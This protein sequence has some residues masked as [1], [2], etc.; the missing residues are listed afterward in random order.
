VSSRER[1][2]TVSD[3]TSLHVEVWRPDV[4]P[5]FVVVVA[6]GGAEHVHR[7][8]HLAQR[9]NARGGLVFG[10]DHRGQGL[11]DGPRGHVDEFATYARDLREVTRAVEAGLPAS[12][13][14]AACPWFLF[15]H[16]MGGLIA[17]TTLLDAPLEPAW[18]GAIV[19]SPLLALS[20]PVPP[21]KLA[22]G[23]LAARLAP[24]LALPS[25]IPPEAICRD[26]AEVERYARDPRRAT[27]VTAGFFAAMNRA[28]ARTLRD[29]AQLR[30]PML[31]YVG[32]GDRICDPNATRRAFAALSAPDRRLEAFEGYYH[33]LHNEPEALREPVLALVDEWI[34]KRLGPA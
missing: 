24:R 34:E 11:S 1:K 17:L 10:A 22:I 12:E 27:V 13:R 8:E 18:R 6:H 4:A 5:R 2:V 25:G 26:P 30:T 14:P 7:Y 16:S 9:W 20:M 29:V 32:T 15:G 21:V 28:T 33:E 23:K 19:S 31:W 3:G